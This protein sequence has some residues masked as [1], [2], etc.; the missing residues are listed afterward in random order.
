VFGDDPLGWRYASALFGALSLVGVYL[1]ALAL[2]RDN[3]P[4]LWATAATFVD[5]ALYVQARIAMLDI[6]ALAF[7][8]LG[9]A[10]FTATWMRA[11]PLRV[12]N[13]FLIAGVCFGL[14]AACKWS[15]L[16]P[17]ALS[18]AI[19]AVVKLF[20]N[21]RM[22]FAK[23]VAGDWFR[24]DLWRDM[25]GWDWVLCLVLAPSLA[26]YLAFATMG[27][28]TLVPLNFIAAQTHI[29]GENSTLS[30]THPYMSGWPEWPFALRGVWYFFEGEHWDTSAASAQA[31]L[32]LGNPLV[33]L[34]GLVA[35]IACALSWISDRRFE[36]F[37]ILAAYAAFWLCW[38]IL[39][40]TLTFAFYY[41]P[42]ST[43][44]SLAL[45]YLF[46]RTRLE[47][48]PWTRRLFLFAATAMFLYFLPISN[49][50]VRVSEPGFNASMWLKSW[51]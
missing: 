12:R 11:P 47:R 34:G 14:S 21:W 33:L 23:P 46:Y 20:Q 31:V 41:L 25:S 49:A 44:L 51:R 26:Y 38:A 6:F 39:P 19:V 32:Y 7:S 43:V 37:I 45:A 40:R 17:L 9:M 36:A 24:P 13:L 16:V 35:A 29:W 30:G 1:W 18:I 48:W 15:G 50:A 2:F 8:L 22:S 42:A 3:R 10:A 5:Q 4:A 28:S 27:Y